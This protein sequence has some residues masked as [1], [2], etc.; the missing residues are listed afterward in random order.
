MALD[1]DAVSALYNSG[2]PLL[3][4]SDSG[5]YDNSDSLMGYWRNDSNSTWT[6]RANTGVASFDGSK[7]IN[8]GNIT[9]INA[10]SKISMCAWVKPDVLGNDDGIMSKGNS[11]SNR[12]FMAIKDSNGGVISGI[13]NGSSAYGFTPD[14]ALSVGTWAFVATVFDGT[15]STDADRLKI[16]VNGVLQSLTYSG[17]TASTTANISNNFNIG[18]EFENSSRM[19]FGQMASTSLF[20][21]ALTSAE[22]S[23]LYVIDKRSSISG[24]SQF[25]N[26]VGSWLMGAGTGDTTSIVQDQSTANNDGT[27]NG[28]NLIGYND[29]TASNN[30]VSIVIPEGNTEGRDNQGYYL[31]DTISTSNNGLRMYGGGEII[32]IQDS[33]IFH[34]G[35]QDFTFEFW[36][37]YN[38]TSTTRGLF[39]YFKD[40]NNRYHLAHYSNL[41]FY[42]NLGGSAQSTATTHT[43]DLNWHH[44][45]ITKESNTMKIYVD[46]SVI[47]T[48]SSFTQDINYTGGTF[49]IGVRTD[50]GSDFSSFNVDGAIDEFRIYHKALSSSEITKNYNSGKSAHQ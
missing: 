30:P 17:T 25:S 39:N 40:V 14:S 29:G 44:Y 38:E 10:V 50:D 19:L 36:A 9:E 4:T 42:S 48:N 46:T 23:E 41:E 45:V 1:A 7:N 27:L 35:T 47:V 49:Y 18:I 24:H 32:H 43:K 31:S 2:V 3:P 21:V 15:Q 16:Y 5:N 13:S 12:T 33:N 37:K 11:A 26:C 22:V 20:D 28:V 6:D 34:L 8:C